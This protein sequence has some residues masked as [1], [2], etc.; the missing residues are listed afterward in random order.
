MK[1]GTNEPKKIMILV[2]LLVVAG[3]V[4]LMNRSESGPPREAAAPAAKMPPAVVA[5]RDQTSAMVES[6]RE[7]GPNVSRRG[8]ASSNQEFRPSLKRDPKDHVD[9]MRID[10]T[11]RLD[12]LAKLQ[13]VSVAGG[14][15]SL[16]DFSAAP[17]PPAPK[18]PEP[19]IK[20]GDV[21]KAISDSVGTPAA[22][23]EPAKPPP[24][25]IPLKFYGFTSP[26]RQ[27]QKRAFFL[28]GEEIVVATEGELIK[29][30]YKVIR[31]GLTSAVLEDTQQKDQ[32]TLP[33]VAEFMG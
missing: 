14:G 29:K 7:S 3:V 33:L 9:P 16:F 5:R 13:T 19:K 6:P 10:P 2:G 12:L 21:Q 15:R 17:P 25:P 23:A 4:Y 8:S 26:A 28:D 18:T 22:S 32:Q 30:R 11:L 27:G 31:I 1:L 20:V 24:T